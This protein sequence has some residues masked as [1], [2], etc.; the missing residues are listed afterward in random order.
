MSCSHDH[1]GHGHDH[2]HHD[3]D[4]H[5][6]PDEGPSDLLYSSISLSQVTSLN[7]TSSTSARNVFKPWNERNRGDAPGEEGD[8]S[9]F[10][11]SDAD[12]QLVL[13]VPFE[14]SCK[15]KSILLKCG[16]GQ[17]LTPDSVVLFA[18]C[19]PP[20]DFSEDLEARCALPAT[21][22]EGPKQKLESVAVAKDVVEYPLRVA[23]FSGVRD[24]TLF[25]PSSMGGEKTRIYYVG[26]RGESTMFRREG[27]TNLVYEAT[28][29][30]KDHKKI[31]GTEAGF[32][33]LGS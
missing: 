24:V 25:V 1:H 21:S 31:P 5:I 17:D 22:R 14:G 30:L 19:D 7:T 3:D 16:P 27:P 10:L 15:L 12:D 11:E 20:L 4:S 18:N 32:D 9:L 2:S 28:P 23:R 26:F 33:R 13:R 29:Q 8:T 6:H